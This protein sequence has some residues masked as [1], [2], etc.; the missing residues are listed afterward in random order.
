VFGCSLLLLW[1]EHRASV[2]VLVA[3]CYC[4]GPNTEQVVVFFSVCCCCG[5]NTGQE[6]VFSLDKYGAF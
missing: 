1:S 3:V 5:P 2:C 4:C 6:F